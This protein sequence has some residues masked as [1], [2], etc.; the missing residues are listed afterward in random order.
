[1][2]K[3]ALSSK[4]RLLKTMEAR[5]WVN[6][7]IEFGEKNYPQIPVDVFL[8]STG[9]VYRFHF[10]TEHEDLAGMEKFLNE[11]STDQAWRNLFLKSGDLF[12][13]G[14]QIWYI[15]I[16]GKSI[17]VPECFSTAFT[18]LLDSGPPET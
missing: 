8:E 6:D 14:S 9:D 10:H 16:S 3:Q 4:A 18:I 11:L 13:K 17:N 12:I 1:M 7:F 15:T 2:I 5:Q